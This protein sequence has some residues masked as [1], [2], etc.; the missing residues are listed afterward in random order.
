MTLSV[1]VPTKDRGE[2]LPACLER[3]KDARE[4]IVS[5]DGEVSVQ[6]IVR[7]FSNV[8]WVQGPR[9]GPAANRNNGARYATGDWLAFVDDDCIP[10]Q[11]WLVEMERA[12]ADT[13]VIEGK[14]ICPDRMNRFLEEVVENLSGDLLWSCNLAIRREL[15]DALKGF[16][17]DFLEAGG[18]DLEFAWRVRKKKLRVRFA[19]QAIVQHPARRVSLWKAIYRVFQIR[20]HLL[21]RLKTGYPA[22]A[23]AQEI[24]DFLRVTVRTSLTRN[25]TKSQLFHLLLRWLLLPFWVPCLICWE[26]VFRRRLRSNNTRSRSS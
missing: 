12:M 11:S 19:S 20:W 1:V 15:F 6:P 17:E 25:R 3:L 18:E 26:I 4:I 13:D 9:R 8:R 22:C 5:D 7:R 23:A 14:T 16:D 21:Y 24:L 10:E 2:S